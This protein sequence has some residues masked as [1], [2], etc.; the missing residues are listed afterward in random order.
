MKS[1]FWEKVRAIPYYCWILAVILLVGIFLRTYHFHDWLRFNMDQGRDALLVQ[2]VVEGHDAPPLLGPRA[3]GT[4]FKLGPVFYYFQIMSAKIFGDYPDNLAYPDFFFSILAIPLL[5]LFLRKYFDP[6]VSLSAT[7]IFAVSSF[8]IQYSRFAWNPNSTPF[9]TILS[10]YGLH[11]LI[12]RNNNRKMLWAVIT[13]IAIGIVIQLHTMSLF[14][15]TIITAAVFGYL[16]LKKTNLL[17]YLGIILIMVAFCNIPQFI[18]ESQTHGQNSKEFVKGVIIQL[19]KPTIWSQAIMHNSVCWVEDDIYEITGYEISDS[20][21]LKIDKTHRTDIL[22]FIMGTIFLLGGVILGIRYLWQEK[23]WNRKAFLAL[24][25]L[26]IFIAYVL[27]IFLVDELIMRYFVMMIIFPFLFIGF[28]MKFVLEKFKGRKG[29]L[30]FIAAALLVLSNLFF[31]RE[32]FA[33]YASAE[34]GDHSGSTLSEVSLEEIEN[35][36]RFIV[37]NSAG[38]KVVYLDGKTQLVKKCLNSINFLAQKS[39]VK[40]LSYKKNDRPQEK[41]FYVSG[42]DS[43]NKRRMIKHSKTPIPYVLSGRLLIYLKN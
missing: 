37:A 15:F 29:Q 25:F 9:W 34:K 21:E 24:I 6:L 11:N 17:K 5:F 31:V 16:Y 33:Y 28:W 22:I 23:D 10:L 32:S 26:Y 30:I 39:G 3:S 38:Q 12:S 43:H 42:R 35:A 19:Q 8:V 40:V 2:G 27:G 18:H 14:F 36:A 7:A 4:R 1:A 20:C 41:V 13:G